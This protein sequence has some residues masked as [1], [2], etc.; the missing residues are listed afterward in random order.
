MAALSDEKP[1]PYDKISQAL[2][3]T[4]LHYRLLSGQKES[5]YACQLIALA[6][7]KFESGHQREVGTANMVSASKYS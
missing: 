1:L 6:G 2:E 4:A 7:C 5:R 3:C